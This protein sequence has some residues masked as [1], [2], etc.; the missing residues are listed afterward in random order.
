MYSTFY[1]LM[2]VGFAG[3]SFYSVDLKSKLLG[4]LI[5]F[6]NAIIFWRS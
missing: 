2:L 5:F 4:V 6:V 3:V 1:I